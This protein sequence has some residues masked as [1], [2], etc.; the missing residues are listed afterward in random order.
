M[1]KSI[2][3]EQD[4]VVSVNNEQKGRIVKEKDADELLRKERVL[5][6]SLP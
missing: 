4:M 6:S 5:K 2:V 1:S 3:A